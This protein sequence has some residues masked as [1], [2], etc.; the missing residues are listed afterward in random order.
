MRWIGLLCRAVGS[1]TVW[2]GG[3]PIASWLADHS[4]HSRKPPWVYPIEES[5]G[6]RRTQITP[7]AGIELPHPVF[8]HVEHGR[9]L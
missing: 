3:V 7:R 6:Q 8:R 2:I 5:C 4:G 9:D 1:V